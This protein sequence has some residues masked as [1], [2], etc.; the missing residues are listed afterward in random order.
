MAMKE[1]DFTRL[2]PILIPSGVYTL[3]ANA[4][5]IPNKDQKIEIYFHQ[6]PP[7]SLGAIKLPQLHIEI[8]FHG[9]EEHKAAHFMG[10]LYRVY[11]RGGG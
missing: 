11:Q 6:Q 3:K 9:Y 1:A 8:S 2:L 7:L 10:K 5:T 4:V